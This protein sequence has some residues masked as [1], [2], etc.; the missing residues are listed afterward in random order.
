MLNQF[1]DG[2]RY[3]SSIWRLLDTEDN[4]HSIISG[5]GPN[6]WF[7]GYAAYNIEA[8]DLSYTFNYLEGV[9]NEQQCN[10]V[11]DA[12][13]SRIFNQDYLVLGKPAPALKRQHHF[14]V[15]SADPAHINKM[16]NLAVSIPFDVPI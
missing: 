1:L 2:S 7:Y 13:I 6:G 15:H 8:A 12:V 11:I 9:M 4:I 5:R 10:S 14:E 3:I 16:I